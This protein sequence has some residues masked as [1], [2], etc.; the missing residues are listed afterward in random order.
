MKQKQY[1]ICAIYL[2]RIAVAEFSMTLD[3][4]KNPAV[5]HGFIARTCHLSEHGIDKAEL[6]L[7]L[8]RGYEQEEELL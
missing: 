6:V 7:L 2:I 3:H 4:P 5:G 8:D 1:I